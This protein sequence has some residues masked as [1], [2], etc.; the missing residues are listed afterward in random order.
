MDD[1]EWLE[2]RFGM[3]EEILN[4][5]WAFKQLRQRGKEEGRQEGLQEGL[6]EG[7]QEGLQEGRAEARQKEFHI[8]LSFVQARFPVL[9]PLAEECRKVL[10]STETVEQLVLKVVLAQSEEE[11]REHLQTALKP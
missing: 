9:T 5:T 11:A 6:Q 10:A 2:R 4:E 3:L 1:Q 8:L 7:R